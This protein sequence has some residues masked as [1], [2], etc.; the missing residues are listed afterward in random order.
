MV[1]FPCFNLSDQPA[2]AEY[3]F[4]SLSWTPNSFSSSAGDYLIPYLFRFFK[5]GCKLL[6]RW[7]LCFAD[8]GIRV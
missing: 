8:E 5:R 6:F 2:F 1:F 7:R 3:E 4:H